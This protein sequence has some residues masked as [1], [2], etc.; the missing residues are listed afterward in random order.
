VPS[1]ST[2]SRAFGKFAE[3][4]L[5]ERV[6]QPLGGHISQDASAFEGR[7]KPTAKPKPF[8]LAPLKKRPLSGRGARPQSSSGADRQLLKLIS[9][10][11][12]KRGVIGPDYPESGFL[13]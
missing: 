10:S 8:E 2:F 1:E 5:G 7:K 3:I 4:G 9:V 12:V 13:R 11:D 6:R